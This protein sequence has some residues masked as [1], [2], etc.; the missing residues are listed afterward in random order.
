MVWAS[1]DGYAQTTPPDTIGSVL[2][3][4]HNNT[5]FASFAAVGGGTCAINGCFVSLAA[6][7][8]GQT[9]PPDTQ[10]HKI[11]VLLCLY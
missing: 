3:N 10:C 11:N 6:T 8:S 7:V 4:V 1:A 9:S 5:R 2:A